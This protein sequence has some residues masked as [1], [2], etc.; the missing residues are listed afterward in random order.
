MEFISSSQMNAGN[1]GFLKLIIMFEN[2]NFDWKTI[3]YNSNS[4]SS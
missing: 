1:Q 2:N 4:F 3:M